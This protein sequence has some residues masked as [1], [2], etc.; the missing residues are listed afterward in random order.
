MA[1]KRVL[2][3]AL[4]DSAHPTGDEVELL[5][6]TCRTIIGLRYEG[7]RDWEQV[8]GRLEQAGWS[9]HWRLGWI[10]EAKRG[11]EF[12]RAAGR[13]RE[14]ALVELEKLTEMDSAVAG[15]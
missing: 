14:E 11:R 13:T 7:S 5:E 15:Y 10:A 6:A 12:E 4:P 1:E 8:M 2:E 3:I 9:V